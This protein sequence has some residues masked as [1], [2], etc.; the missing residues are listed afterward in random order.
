MPA[1]VLAERVRWSGSASWFREQVAKIRPEYAPADPADRIVYC[2]G[3]QA[4]CDLWFPPAV[5]PDTCGAAGPPVLVMVASFSRF[6]TATMLPTR[7]TADLLA[8]TWSL[9]SGQLGAVP[10]RLVWDNEAGIGRRNHFAAGVTAFTGALATNI[11]QLKPFDP[12][13]KGIVERAN[14][15][16]ETS[17][18]PGRRFSSAQDFNTQLT[19]WLPV[20][21]RR[22]VRTLK[23]RPVDLIDQDRQAMLALPVLPPTTGSLTGSVWAGTITSVSSATITPSTRSRSDVWSISAPTSHQ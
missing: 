2:A 19:S 6:I 8:G 16:L 7:T 12:E 18:L 21:N 9:L 4:Q 23:A 11:V 22:T 5:V 1:P 15:Y 14:Q 20:A 10:R 3:D 17:F 13:S